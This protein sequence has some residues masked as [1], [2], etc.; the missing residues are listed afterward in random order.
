MFGF[1]STADNPL[2]P[3]HYA[4][5][6]S[7]GIKNICFIFDSKL[8]SEKDRNIWVKRTEN[9]FEPNDSIPK[10]Y[11][12]GE[13]CPPA[14]FVDSHISETSISLYK[15]L[16]IKCLLNA[17]SPRK[18]NQKVINMM[19]KGIVNVHPGILPYYR[20]CSCVEWALYNDDKIGN[21]AHFMSEEYDQGPIIHSEWY[22]FPSDSSYVDIRVKVY[23]ESCILGA[24]CLK[25]IDEGILK[26]SD[27]I[28]QDES[29]ARTWSPIPPELEKAAIIKANEGKYFYQRL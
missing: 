5:A 25:L 23:K 13:E 1:L 19:E 26:Y 21:T 17:G 10:L 12:L 11:R 3:Y 6:K 7:Q 28:V 15:K 29:A 16:K 2:L 8:I 14:Y 9:A 18:I 20:G 24:K 22:E 27:A 4:A